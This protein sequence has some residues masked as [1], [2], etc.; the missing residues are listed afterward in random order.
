MK[1]N[2]SINVALAS[3]L[4]LLVIAEIIIAYYAE[5]GLDSPYLGIAIHVILILIL[6]SYSFFPGRECSVYMP[7]LLIPPLMRIL[8]TSLIGFQ[9]I[10][11]IIIINSLLILTAYLFIKNNKIPLKDIG[12]STGN[13]KLQLFIGATGIL[14]GYTEYIILGEQIIGEVIFPT[15]IAY[16]F[17]LFLFTGFSEELVFRGIILTNLKSVIGRN[18]ALVFVSLV[19]T[20][21]HIIWKN[22]L[23]ILFVFFVAL[24]YGYVFLKTKSLLGI[25]MSH[26]LANIMLF[27]VI[28]LYL[29]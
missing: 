1:S 4:M 27:L 20:V 5:L 21:M 2:R 26:G 12:I 11:T 22:P 13:V 24:F 18:Y 10:H 28:P 23:D 6:L 15:F 14:L 9:F 19:F 17:A 3:Y 7:I 29:H 16:S 8:S 25:S